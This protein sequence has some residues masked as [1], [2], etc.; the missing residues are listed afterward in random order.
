MTGPRPDRSPAARPHRRRHRRPRR[1]FTLLELMVAAMIGAM[2]LGSLSVGIGRIADARN[3]SKARLDAF[4]RADAALAALR[5]E[6]ATIIR[7]D[8]LFDTRLLLLDGGTD[9]TPRDEVL[10]FT[11][12]LK[13]SR[14]DNRFESDGQEWETAFRVEED[15]LGPALWIRRDAVPDEFSQ[16]GGIA[17]PTVEG[18]L[19]IAV[20]C[21]DGFQW[22]DEWDSDRR[23][24]P[25]AVRLEVTA[26]GHRRDE[27]PYDAPIAALRTTVAIDRLAPPRDIY[28]QIEIELDEQE[29]AERAA[30]GGVGGGG[31][32]AEGDG[33]V[34]GVG[35][36]AVPGGRPGG[37]GAGGGLGGGG[38]AGGGGG[39]DRPGGGRP[40]V[41]PGGG[42]TGT[43]SGGGG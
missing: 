17:E 2:V 15:D 14:A 4:M 19:S 20:S 43:G 11:T 1:G 21:W 24:L 28:E 35:G 39:G 42:G 16:G 26:S 23:G 25:K 12:R 10:L 5:R 31:L 6:V 22:F 37:G 38:G 34:G 9:E 27:D 36:G 8:D 41:R 13:V 33:G 30:A 32:G 3:R 18:I 7:S 40:P 29:A